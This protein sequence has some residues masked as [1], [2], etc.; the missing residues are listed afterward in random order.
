MTKHRIVMVVLTLSSMFLLLTGFN[1]AE[2][3]KDFASFDRA[4]IPP[5]ALTRGEKL[6][7]SKKGMKLLKENW[8]TFKGKY[9]DANPKDPEWKEDF[10]KMEKV[11]M[12][13]AALIKD[14]KDLIA[15]HEELEEIRII[16]MNLRKR[17]NIQYYIDPL[18]EFHS[19][20]EEI[21]HTAEDHDPQDMTE[22]DIK[23]LA[24][25]SSKALKLW[26]EIGDSKF[27]KNLFGFNNKKMGKM[28]KLYEMESAALDKLKKALEKKDRPMIKKAGMG[29]KPNYAKYY[30]LFGDFESI[31]KK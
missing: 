14:G 3:K 17:N 12:K 27:D 11:I 28:K 4:F 18:T 5:L 16:T 7:P 22:K 23:E 26:K 8:G 13:A 1:K 2:L 19:L 20:M 10:D 24:D 21:F 30:K 9:Y 25:L 29:I 6:K 31:M 15:A